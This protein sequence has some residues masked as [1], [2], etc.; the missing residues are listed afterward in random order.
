MTDIPVSPALT[1][2]HQRF[3][4]DPVQ[5]LADLLSGSVNLG[6]YNRARPADALAQLIIMPEDVAKADQALLAWL[7]YLLGKPTPEGL[8]NKRFADTLVEAFRAVEHIPLPTTRTWLAGRH[9][10][11]RLWLRG[12]YGGATRDP[13]SAFLLTLAHGQTNRSLLGLWIGLTRFT[14]ATPQEHALIGLAGLRLMPADDQGGIERNLPLILLRGLLE[15]GEALARNGE[16]KGKAWLRELDFL[17]AIY[18]M[19]KEQ[20]GKRFRQVLQAR[21][22][23]STVQKWLDQRYPSA[24]HQDAKP[25]GRDRIL[26]APYLDELQALLPQIKSHLDIARPSLVSFIDRHRKYCNDSGDSYYLVRTFCKLGDNLLNYDP[27]WARDLAHEAA[28]WAPNNPYPWSLLARALEKEGDWRRA[29]AVYWHARRRFPHDVQCHSQLA[30]SLLLHR[31]D[32]TAAAI[33]RQAV[34]LFPANPFCQNDLAHTL[35][36]AGRRE[37]AVEVYRA[38]QRQFA[39]DEVVANAL[40]DTLIDLGQLPE[41]QKALDYAEQVVPLTNPKLRQISDRLQGALAGRPITLG[42]RP[43]TREGVAG[44]LSALSDIT[45]SALTDA[46]A[47]GLTTLWR[48]QGEFAQAKTAWEAILQGP[49]RLI[50]TGLWCAV[51]E[52]WLAA[53]AYFDKYAPLYEG[54]GVVR[55]H[56]LRAHKRA[57]QEVDWSMEKKRYPHLVPIIRT[58]EKGQPPHL[59]YDPKNEDLSLEQQQDLWFSDLVDKEEPDLRDLAEE[60]LLAARHLI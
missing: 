37:E 3:A 43:T 28:R 31:Q 45:G 60:D 14:G 5:A 8:S 30:H 44:D 33:L 4:A 25:T 18:P 42:T 49:S 32:D 7:E 13:E 48:R 22:A 26:S 53:A 59:N 6:P 15:M 38:A 47:L 34:S 52:D 58:E 24:S 19:S 57:G 11:L 41:A 51:A 12:F 23:T 27:I 16:R 10:D 21:P 55:V 46:T 56:R 50:E 1:R 36:L 40:T 39:R 9:G 29:E 17:A 20:W 35:R 2:W 54:D